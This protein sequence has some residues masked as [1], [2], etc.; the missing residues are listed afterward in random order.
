MDSTATLTWS[1]S[2]TINRI[3][4][5]KE[6]CE[7][8]LREDAP[9]VFAFENVDEIDLS[10]LQLLYNALQAADEAGKQVSFL[11]YPDSL[12]TMI[13]EAGLERQLHGKISGGIP[14]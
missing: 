9:L 5:L 1:G 13:K 4:E 6:Q 2:L 10:F 11:N 14:E 8:Q 3:V 7:E 12:E